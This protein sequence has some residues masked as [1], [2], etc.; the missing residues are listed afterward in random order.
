MRSTSPQTI[1]GAFARGGRPMIVVLP[2]SKTVYGGSMYSSS[3]T[4]GDFE[5]F[6]A[7]DLVDYI[8]AH[9]RTIPDRSSRGLVGHSMGGY[10]AAHIGMKHPAVTRR[11]AAPRPSPRW[12]SPPP[13][14]PP[15]DISALSGGSSRATARSLNS[16]PYRATVVPQCPQGYR[17]IEATT[18]V[19]RGD[20]CTAA[21]NALK[22]QSEKA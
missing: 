8:D 7:H 6:I 4:T 18:T 22:K 12:Q 21:R 19:T 14:A 16:L 13:S 20:A 1:A 2:D 3:A 5:R 10:G 15:L 11:C 9:Y 17:G